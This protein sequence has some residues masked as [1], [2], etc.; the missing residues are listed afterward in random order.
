MAKVFKA[1]RDFGKGELDQAEAAFAEAA[2]SGSVFAV[3]LYAHALSGKGEAEGDSVVKKQLQLRAATK[4]LVASLLGDPVAGSWAS[5][6]G[7]DVSEKVRPDPDIYHAA[8]RSALLEYQV[9]R[10]ARFSLGLGDFPV[11]FRYAP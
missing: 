10:D 4:F 5:A 3:E 1:F 2:A 8:F 7:M 9:L 11:S 6:V